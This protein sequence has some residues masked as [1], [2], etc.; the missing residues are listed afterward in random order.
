VTTLLRDRDAV[1]KTMGAAA[2]GPYFAAMPAG[3][4]AVLRYVEGLRAAGVLLP[5]DLAV[6]EG[7]SGPE[8]RHA[9]VP[10]PT[11]LEL[12]GWRSAEFLAA[13]T[14]IAR[15]VRT[16]ESGN[17]R[18]DANLAN[19]VISD[20][21]GITCVDVLPPLLVPLRPPEPGPW[22]QVIGGLCFDTDV[23]LCALAGYAARHLL[24]VLKPGPAA[25]PFI[26]RA[27]RICPGHPQPGALA[28][29]WF[30]S[31]LRAAELAAAARISREQA[32]HLL[33]VTSVRA[34]QAAPAAA[35]GQ[36]ADAA[37]AL[38]GSVLERCRP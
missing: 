11:L 28:A 32:D 18:L 29:R 1:V 30:H 8:V 5:D 16:L 33:N 38:T 13:V 35:R 10:G 4:L 24:R 6:A 34:L 14:R 2:A 15:W 31:R 26:G 22:E 7:A 23:T 19:F 27:L 37:L 21:G 17:A 36:H 20:G 3:G 12:P 25:L 9:W